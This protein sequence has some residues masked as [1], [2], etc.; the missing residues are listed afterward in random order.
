M[1]SE[2]STKTGHWKNSGVP[3]NSQTNMISKKSGR[4][5]KFKGTEDSRKNIIRKKKVNK[6]FGG[7]EDSRKNMK[8]RKNMLSGKSDEKWDIRKFRGYRRAPKFGNIMI[9]RKIGHSKNAW[10]PGNP[11][12]NMIFEKTGHPHISECTFVVSCDIR[13]MITATF[14]T[15]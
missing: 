8:T 3:R 6:N 11:G 1:I 10:V 9:S 14:V 7:T 13:S 12:K 2:D 15:S 4:S 5:E